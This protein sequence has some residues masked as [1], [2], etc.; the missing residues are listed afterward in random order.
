MTTL[1]KKHMLLKIHDGT[2]T[3]THHPIEP[4]VKEGGKCRLKTEQF[5]A[6]PDSI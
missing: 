1:F 4:M 5:K 3:A 2:K 6:H